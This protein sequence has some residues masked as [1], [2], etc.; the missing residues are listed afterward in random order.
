MTS[1]TFDARERALVIGLGRSGVASCRVL[2][3]R[4]AT[5]Y[6]TD[7]K[8]SSQLAAAIDDLERAGVHF[9]AP[10]ALETIG[11]ELT[12]CVLS[13][14]VPVNGSIVRRV[15]AMRVPVYSE[16]EVAYRISKAPLVAITGTK[17]KR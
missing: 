14:G 9:V 7:E 11:A 2:R 15:Q 8:P 10:D 4:G 17:G 13:P 5:V 6:A 3:A 12:A 16:I 1:G